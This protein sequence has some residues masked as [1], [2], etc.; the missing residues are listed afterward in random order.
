MTCRVARSF[1]NHAMMESFY[2]CKCGSTHMERFFAS[3][4]LGPHLCPMCA[5]P[6][7][8]CGV[9]ESMTPCSGKG[10]EE[11]SDRV[12]PQTPQYV[13]SIVRPAQA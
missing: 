6:K 7:A 11:A 2:C 5:Q 4:A 13:R 9:A 3:N 8:E 1:Q 12:P 10:G